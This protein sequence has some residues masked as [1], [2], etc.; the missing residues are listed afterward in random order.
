MK[1]P[2]ADDVAGR[3][4]D[5]R[6]AIKEATAAAE[7]NPVDAAD[8]CGVPAFV[9]CADQQVPR[10]PFVLFDQAAKNRSTLDPFIAEVGH[11][12]GRSWR[13]S[14]RARCGRRPLF[15]FPALRQWRPAGRDLAIGWPQQHGRN[16]AGLPQANQTSAPTRSNSHGPVS[17]RSTL[18]AVAVHLQFKTVPSEHR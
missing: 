3:H 4:L 15:R 14:P 8:S 9:V 1:E 5:Q 6:G 16:R 18:P 7:H 12:V 10:C 13:T 2:V 17:R 11:G